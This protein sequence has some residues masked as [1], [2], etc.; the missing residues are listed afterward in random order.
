MQ[1]LAAIISDRI[2][3]CLEPYYYTLAADKFKE[4][5]TFTRYTRLYSKISK[6]R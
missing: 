2:D 1:V 4:W 3:D 6:P 5:K